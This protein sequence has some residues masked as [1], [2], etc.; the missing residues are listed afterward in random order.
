LKNANIY[1]LVAQG[2]GQA[3]HDAGANSMTDIEPGKREP[4]LSAGLFYESQQE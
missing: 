4:L 1:E 3:E 2:K